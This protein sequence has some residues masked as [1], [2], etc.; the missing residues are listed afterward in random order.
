MQDLDNYRLVQINVQCPDI[1]EPMSWTQHTTRTAEQM[2]DY[3][4][5]VGR[6]VCDDKRIGHQDQHVVTVIDLEDA[7][8]VSHYA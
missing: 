4:A 3:G 6:V 7:D 2:I 8:R 5:T 1:D